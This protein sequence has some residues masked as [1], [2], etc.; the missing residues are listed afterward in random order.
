MP[1]ACQR[2][3]KAFACGDSRYEIKVTMKSG[4]DGWLPDYPVVDFAN[5]LDELVQKLESSS[6]RAERDVYY[7]VEIV[8][9]YRCRR[10]LEEVL[11]DFKKSKEVERKVH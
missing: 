7:E 8:L 4:F 11:A 5:E 6:E 9:C 10:E 2:C 1:D 3:G